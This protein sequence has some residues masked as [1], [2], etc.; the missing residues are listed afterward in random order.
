MNSS[1]RIA[2]NCVYELCKIFI[3]LC[4]LVIH[5]INPIHTVVLNSC[6]YVPESLR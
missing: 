2:F 3:Y 4:I 5:K 1:N 6:H